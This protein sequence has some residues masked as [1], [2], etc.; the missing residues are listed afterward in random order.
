MS[1]NALHP[2]MLHCIN[3]IE[4]MDLDGFVPYISSHIDFIVY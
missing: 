1:Y 3:L 2:T 4:I